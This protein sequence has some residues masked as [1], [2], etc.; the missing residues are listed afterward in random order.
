VQG[1][2]QAHLTGCLDEVVKIS[3]QKMLYEAGSHWARARGCHSLHLGG[4]VGSREDSLL[5]FKLGFSHTTHSFATW[6][7]VVDAEAADSLTAHRTRWMEANQLVPAG[8]DYFP[9]YRMPA[10]RAEV[11]PEA[12]P[13]S[14]ACALLGALLAGGLTIDD[15]L[16]ESRRCAEH[17]ASSLAHLAGISE[18]AAHR[19]RPHTS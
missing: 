13:A 6:Q 10:T 9:S 1:I 15:G 4:G 5:H 12:G 14:R 19:A 8:E 18:V 11:A 7:W 2:A 17:S 3:P 16:S